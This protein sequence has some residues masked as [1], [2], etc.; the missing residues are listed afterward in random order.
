[1][2]SLIYPSIAIDADRRSSSGSNNKG[3]SEHESAGAGAWHL[4]QISPAQNACTGN[5]D[6]GRRCSCA[7][8][9]AGSCHPAESAEALGLASAKEAELLSLMAKLLTM[10]LGLSLLAWVLA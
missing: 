1:M 3:R 6:Q 10:T 5:C 7:L 8:S 2:S 9:V 4:P